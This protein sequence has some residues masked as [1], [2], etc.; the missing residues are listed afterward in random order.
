[1]TRVPLS[2][3][4]RQCRLLVIGF[5]AFS[6]CTERAPTGPS[7]SGVA[8]ARSSGGSGPTVRSTNPDSATVDTTLNVRVL[9]SGYDQGSRANWAFKGVPSAKVVTN[10]TQFVSS[11]ELVANI[12]IA[13]DANIG[14]YDVIVTTSSGKGGIGTELFAITLK[15]I[16]LGTL[17]GTYARAYAI[18]N[19]GDIVGVSKPTVGSQRATFWQK[20]SGA[21]WSIRQLSAAPGESQS[22][23]AGINDAGV[24]AGWTYNQGADGITQGDPVRWLS[25]ASAPENLGSQGWEA[26][27]INLAGQILGSMTVDSVTH[28]FLW[29]N[30]VITDLGHLGGGQSQGFRINSSGDIVGYS[31]V[32]PFP[33]GRTRAVV[34]KAGVIKELPA[35]PGGT[36]DAMAYNIND[37]GIIVGYSPT[38]AGQTH[39][40]RW[41]P[42]SSEPSGYRIEDLGLGYSVARGINKYGEIVGEYYKSPAWRPFYWHPVSGK[43]DLPPLR[44]GA[45]AQALAINDARVVVGSGYPRSSG[46]DMHAIVWIGIP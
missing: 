31:R 2:G 9:G 4:L 8:L 42:A 39:A 14:R 6:A 16:D 21:A 37:A 46:S 33:D 27:G 34:W 19:S 24:I 23:A 32:I 44:N 12:T 45:D 30:G 28:G 36:R 22:G 1:M 15:A 20:V 10:S 25:Q 40:V 7:P 41:V 3:L 13:R 17:G 43:I 11:T 38:A 35:L 26:G 5:L 18:N 29:E